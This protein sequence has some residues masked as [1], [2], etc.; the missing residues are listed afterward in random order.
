MKN[1]L[2]IAAPNRYLQDV[3][4]PLV[5][6]VIRLEV[7]AHPRRLLDPMAS[8]KCVQTSS[9]KVLADMVINANFPTISRRIKAG[10]HHQAG[11][12]LPMVLV[13]PTTHL[14]F[15]LDQMTVTVAAVVAV[16]QVPHPKAT[17]TK[18]IT[19]LPKTAGD[20]AVNMVAPIK[21]VTVGVADPQA[22]ETRID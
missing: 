18:A 19:I 12:L 6:Q 7:R 11:V 21:T 13:V 5:L 8:V 9:T 22:A 17:T 15:T 16:L 2:R 20:Q 3:R 14:R 10:R 4:V 1:G